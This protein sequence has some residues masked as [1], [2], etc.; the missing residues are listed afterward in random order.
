MFATIE[1]LEL[2]TNTATHDVDN[3]IVTAMT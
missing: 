2:N 1:T 3:R